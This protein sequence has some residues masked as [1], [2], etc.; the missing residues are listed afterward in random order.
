VRLTTFTD[1]GLRVLMFVA[2][3][4]DG[5]ATIA[6]VASA[7][8][9]S[10]NHLVKVVHRLG[11]IGA[12]VNTRGRGGGV[13]LAAPA[14][15]I[16]VGSIVRA[17][18]D[19]DVP[20]ACFDPHAAPCRIARTCRLRGALSEAMETFYRTLDR[21]TVADLVEH[22]APLAMALHEPRAT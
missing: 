22:G 17:L 14:A 8:G 21:Y 4:S 9:I 16:R 18:E 13:R 15:R 1:Y 2:S 10:E 7:Y 3:E 5:R 6:Q 12:L 11:R 20:A 19:G